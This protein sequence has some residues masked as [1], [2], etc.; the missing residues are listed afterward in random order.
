LNQ[1]FGAINQIT[2]ALGQPNRFQMLV[3][4]DGNPATVESNPLLI[5]D[6]T[7]AD[8]SLYITSALTPVLGAPTA[9]AVGNLYGR[10]D[11]LVM[12]PPLKITYYRLRE[13]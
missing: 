13:Q 7:Q 2:T 9:T 5:V 10:A 11:M 8:L 1:L 3:T 12:Q 4:D 6:E